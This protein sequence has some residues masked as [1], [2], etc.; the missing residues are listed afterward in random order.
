MADAA[1][2][3][4]HL[5]CFSPDEAASLR[6][7]PVAEA[8]TAALRRHKDK[9]VQFNGCTALHDLCQHFSELPA[10]LRR[11][12]TVLRTVRAAAAVDRRLERECHWYR[13]L[14]EWLAPYLGQCD[15]MD[16]V[17]GENN[18]TFQ[19]LFEDRTMYNA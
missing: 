1:D 9:D 19:I 6:P 17:D 18:K 7:E 14:C 16:M 2:A 11:D 8:V 4:A 15:D 13:E 10:E 5:L 3:V 12:P